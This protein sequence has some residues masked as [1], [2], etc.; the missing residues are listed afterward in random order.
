[1]QS[2]VYN[3]LRLAD[4][5]VRLAAERDAA[6]RLRRTEVRGTLA[7]AS[8]PTVTIESTR[9]EGV[10]DGDTLDVRARLQ[11]DRERTV[12]LDA[13][14]DPRPGRARVT[15]RNVDLKLG[16]DRWALLQPTTVR[17]G[18]AYRVSGLLLT[19]QDQQIAADGVIDV[20]GRQSFVVTIENVELGQVAGLAGFEGLGGRLSGAIDLTGPADAPQ[21]DGD[22]R[23]NVRSEGTPV[24]TLDLGVRYDSLAVTL[25][26]RLADDGGSTFTARGR[27]PADLRLAA[28]PG[29][30]APDLGARPVDLVVEADAF[31]VGWI[32]PFLDRALVQRPAGRLAARV[33]VGGT[34]DAPAL[35]GE[36]TLQDGRAFVPL[37]DTE[38]RRI[39]ADL[40]FEEERIT[41]RSV[42]ARSAG[43]GRLTADGT[44]ELADLTLGTFDLNLRA[45]DFLGIDVPL[46]YRARIDSDVRL[47]GT[48]DRPRL[49]GDVTVVGGDFYADAAGSQADVADVALTE[50]DRQTLER[51]FGIR[52]AAA[53]TA[54]TD[55]YDALA[56]DSLSL[57]IGRNAWLRKSSNPE[58]DIQF[59]GNLD[60]S[61]RPFQDLDVFGTIEV[62]P[63]RSRLEQYGKVF[64]IE[65][66][67]LGFNG[68]PG[69][70][71]L[72]IT[73]AFEP[74]TRATGDAAVRIL[75]RVEGRPEDPTLTLSSEPPM[76]TSDIFCYIATN[77]PCGEFA[78]GGGGGSGG[79][80]LGGSL[81]TGVALGQAASLVEGLVTSEVG[82]D[83]FRL[84]DRPTGLFL[85][86]GQYLT[87]RLYVG[88][89]QPLTRN[90]QTE[91]TTASQVPD[92]TLEYELQRWLLLRAQRRQTALR[93]NFL[94]EYG[95]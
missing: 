45:N 70:P 79:G 3:A 26:A 92:V 88:V 50:A 31:S 74:R 59:T 58:M 85:V 47:Q 89:E 73:A 46:E 15:L 24:G 25:D 65:E 9:F 29:A 76:E 2:L 52:L 72:D 49:S 7:Y 68:P 81:A 8:L 19:S 55:T 10:F 30:G 64:E 37:L 78:Q 1:M 21:I 17:Y 84:Q 75:L 94:L 77:S 48:T 40:A 69:E 4:G 22:L 42:R 80:S 83:V 90:S 60:V 63:E 16:P 87:P 12:R 39:Q 93:L 23:L 62:V 38:Y 91:N 67:T 53:D 61:K 33:Q 43:D 13:T 34:R 5:E 28:A 44:I 14:L 35:S 41:L 32:G 18:D 20:D 57:R 66:G 82:L 6:G 27:L 86:V 95:Y 54:A 36:A 71:V 56:I 51:R 11:V